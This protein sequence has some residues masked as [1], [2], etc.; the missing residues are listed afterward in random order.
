MPPISPT[1]RTSERPDLA[2]AVAGEIAGLRSRLATAFALDLASGFDDRPP[3]TPTLH[4]S[5]RRDPADEGAP[6]R[7]AAP[8]DAGAL[9]EAYRA[10]VTDP[11]EIV[12]ACLERIAADDGDIGSVITISSSAMDD[13]AVAAARWRDGRAGPLEGVP[14]VVKDII[15]TAGLRTTGGSLWLA[16]R[17]PARDAE[18]VARLKAAGAVVVAKTNTFELACGNEDA[19]FGV[20]HN[21]H[22]LDRTTGGSSSGTAAAV[23]AGYTP[24]GLGSDTGG[25]IRIPSGYCGLVGLRP[26]FALV[27][28]DGVLPLAW[29]FDTIGPM[30]RSVADVALA[31]DVLAPDRSRG[32]VPANVRVGRLGGWMEEVLHSAVLA[33]LE[34]ACAALEAG[35]SPVVPVEWDDVWRCG[36]VVYVI[37]MAECADLH[38]STPLDQLSPAFA[39]RVLVGCELT[40]SELLAAR[41]VGHVLRAQADALFADH[42]VDVL[43]CAGPVQPAPRLDALDAPVATPDGPVAASWLDTGARTMGPWSVTG[44]PVLSLPVGRSPEG[45]PVGVQL[46]ARRGCEDTLFAVGSKLEKALAG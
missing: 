25:S 23:I 4:A 44:L 3:V 20:V 35:G 6:W 7:P 11:T 27:P 30:A 33:G 13:A 10:G 45:L 18:V 31:L 2:E 46:V 19:P 37:T 26:T 12:A 42:D 24:F 22:D 41:R 9:V 15:D 14:V 21:P 34:A 39:A 29:T 8:G 5:P 17:V 43:L 38:R 28:V 16:E 1:T 40:A 32:G 36:L